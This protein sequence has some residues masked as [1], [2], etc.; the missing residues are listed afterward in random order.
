MHT[1]ERQIKKRQTCSFC[2]LSAP[3]MIASFKG[4]T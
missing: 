3:T 2:D 1:K 4:K